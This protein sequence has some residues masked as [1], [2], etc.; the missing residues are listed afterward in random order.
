MMVYQHSLRQMEALTGRQ[1]MRTLIDLDITS[2]LRQEKDVSGAYE[3]KKSR[4]NWTL[5]SAYAR[6]GVRLILIWQNWR[7]AMPSV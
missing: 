6:P 4:P 5:C 2:P 7:T 1:C 3:M